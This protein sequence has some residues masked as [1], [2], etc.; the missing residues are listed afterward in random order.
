MMTNPYPS[1]AQAQL[2]RER[3]RLAADRSLLSFIRNSLILIST[4]IAI[5]QVVIALSSDQIRTNA[6]AHIL[7]LVL[8]GLGT[9]SLILACLDYQGEMKRLKQPEYYF[10]P[11]FSLA[12]VIGF[13]ILA[14]GSFTLGWFVSGV[15]S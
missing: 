10:T 9:I 3:N 11:R 6:F 4:G 8:I 1:D 5:N 15:L 12:T 13:A 2:A 7:S 14:T